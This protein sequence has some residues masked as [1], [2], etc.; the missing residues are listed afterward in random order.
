MC[1]LVEGVNLALSVCSY[2]GWTQFIWIHRCSNTQFGWSR[3]GL[4]NKK[5]F[6]W[7]FQWLIAYFQLQKRWNAAARL[8][9]QRSL[10]TNRVFCT[11]KPAVEALVA[12]DSRDRTA[13]STLTCV[14]HVPQTF[15]AMFALL[16]GKSVWLWPCGL[17][18]GRF[19]HV[20]VSS[21]TNKPSLSVTCCFLGPP[22]CPCHTPYVSP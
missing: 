15:V 10:G 16:A 17:S 3:R 19:V 7:L 14:A 1:A 8:L 13:L 21:R 20:W 18:F 9:M 2:L 4:H 6:L 12:E 22:R 11:R 5:R